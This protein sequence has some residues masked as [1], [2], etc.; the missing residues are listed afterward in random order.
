[1]YSTAVEETAA[2]KGMMNTI[3]GSQLI[4]DIQ[5]E[6]GKDIKKQPLSVSLTATLK[7]RLTQMAHNCNIIKTLKLPVRN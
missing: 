7:L 6:N 1:M 3:S 5:K 2:W 4:R